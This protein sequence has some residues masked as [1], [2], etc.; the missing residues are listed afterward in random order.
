MRI[1]FARP[2]FTPGERDYNSKLEAMIDE[3]G[4][5]RPKWGGKREDDARTRAKRVFD[6]CFAGIAPANAVLAVLSGTEIDDGTAAEIG[7]FYAMMESDP[8]KKG[9][10][11]LLD[12]WRTNAD[13][14]H[15]QGKG[16]N[17]FVL[18]CIRR[19][20]FIVHTPEEAME[21]LRVW[22]EELTTTE[23]GA[24][25]TSDTVAVSETTGRDEGSTGEWPPR[26]YFS[27]PQYTPYA[28][29]FVAEH[30]QLLRDRGVEVYVPRE[31][32]QI[33]AARLSPEE[34]FD[35]DYAAL[36]NST[37]MLALLDGAQPD[38]A[39]AL[40][41]GLFYG[42]H[43]VDPSK[44]GAVGWITDSRGLRRREHGY[45][46]NHFPVGVIEEFGT[47]VETFDD[48]VSHLESPS[49]GT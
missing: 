42:R 49:A 9:I 22:N 36:K 2:I 29:A 32:A 34:V 4:I 8:T 19:G 44:K 33:H 43:L 23:S 1:Y 46:C 48:V 26:V 6:G 17:D 10:I 12:D 7:V 5:G 35:R 28:R 25:A 21:Q 15:M 41:L 14:E 3:L 27:A 24:P 11:G 40:E 30:A 20:G 45:G 16:L 37:A 31:R 47:I 39:V 13:S 18:G 38:D